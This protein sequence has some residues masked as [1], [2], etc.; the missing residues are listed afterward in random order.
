MRLY[1]D[2]P[3]VPLTTTGNAYLKT[4][5]APADEFSLGLLLRPAQAKG[6]LF[7]SL[8]IAALRR[9]NVP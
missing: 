9:Q 1:R 2:E 7:A 5:I 3:S 6:P 8:A 4:D